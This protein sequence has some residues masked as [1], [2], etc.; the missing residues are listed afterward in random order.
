MPVAGFVQVPH[1]ISGPAGCVV[2][3]PQL[4]LFFS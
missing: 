1:H 3:V 2:G 4:N